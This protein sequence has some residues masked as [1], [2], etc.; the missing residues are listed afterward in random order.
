M[1]IMLFVK[2]H[3]IQKLTGELS[4]VELLGAIRKFATW[5]NVS[6]L[7]FMSLFWL[8][9]PLSQKLFLF[10]FNNVWKPWPDL[11]SESV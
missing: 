2:N 7:V 4:F 5:H 9:L 1:E 8:D 10:K 6:V 3:R 11:L